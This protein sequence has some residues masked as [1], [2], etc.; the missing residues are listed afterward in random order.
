MFEET[1]ICILT[2]EFVREI[3]KLSYL[4]ELFFTYL[5]HINLRLNYLTSFEEYTFFF[6]VINVFNEAFYEPR[7]LILHLMPEFVP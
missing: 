6:D 2:C 3:R 7:V 5:T 1:K 4:K